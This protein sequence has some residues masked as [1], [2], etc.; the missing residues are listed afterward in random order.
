M[1]APMQE[2]RYPQEPGVRDDNGNLVD[3][4]ED[5]PTGCWHCLEVIAG[6]SRRCPSH[7]DEWAPAPRLSDRASRQKMH[8]PNADKP[9]C[10]GG[11]RWYV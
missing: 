2:D 10:Q 8:N 7:G 1:T 6:R 5:L 4:Q 9:V 11:P 3:G